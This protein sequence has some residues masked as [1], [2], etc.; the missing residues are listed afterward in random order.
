MRIAL[1]DYVYLAGP[2][3]DCSEKKMK[4]WRNDAARKL[5]SLN[6]DVLNPTRRLSFHDQISSNLEDEVRN[7]NTCKRIFKQ[8]LQDIAESRIVLADVRRKSGRGTGTSC[9][10][11]FA[12][13][14]NKIIVLVSDKEDYIHPFYESMYTEKHYDFDSAIDSIASY[15]Q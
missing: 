13:M 12:H 14:K 8:D 7:M 3:E 5:K 6:I 1:K 15:Y 11:M 10:L 9:E 2:M 4:G